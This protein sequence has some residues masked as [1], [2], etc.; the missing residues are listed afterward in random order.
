MNDLELLDGRVP[1]LEMVD[2][3]KEL[4]IFAKRPGDG[5]Q[6]TDVLRMSPPG[7][8]PATIA[9]GDERGPHGP[10]VAILPVAG[11]GR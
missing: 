3:M 10:C 5:A 6:P 1:A 4:R 8:V 2:G 11:G 9:V 7:V